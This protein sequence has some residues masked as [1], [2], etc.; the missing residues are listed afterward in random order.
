M[1]Q[2]IPPP[3]FRAVGADG[4][5]LVGGKLYSYL[6]GTS[7]P[8][9][10]YQD[11]GFGAS[12][13]NPIILDARG[14][15]EVWLDGNYKFVLTTAA[16]VV[17]WTVDQIRDLTRTQ[18][19]SDMTL[20]GTLLITSSAVTWNNNPI[21]SGTH[22]WNGPQTFNA[23]VTIG[24]NAADTLTILPNAVT[25]TNN[26]THSGNHAFSGNVAI[27]GALTGGYAWTAFTPGVSFGA[28]TTGITYS[29]DNAAISC[30][31]GKTRFVHIR[32]VLSNKGS[33]TGGAKI[34]GL[35]EAATVV[36][37]VDEAIFSVAALGMSGL[38]GSMLGEAILNSTGI[39]LTQWGATGTTTITDARFTNTSVVYV[40]GSYPVA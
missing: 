3:K 27:T 25:W 16:D 30:K 34:T 8:K 28:G 10:T 36:N 24:D 40:S 17:V 2:L 9:V 6:A 5:A 33:S 4:L 35:P 20:G 11:A 38:T 29:I 15:A 19:L 7:T 22:T 21:H 18:T 13:T 1:A 37:N 14:E 26:P 32:L 12:N 23:N 31:V 39:T